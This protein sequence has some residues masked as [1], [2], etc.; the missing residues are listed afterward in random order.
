MK[1]NALI[2]RTAAPRRGDLAVR[3]SFAGGFG[4]AALWSHLAVSMSD[5]RCQETT[6]RGMVYSRPNQIGQPQGFGTL[7]QV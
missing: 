7:V 3:A 5:C 2:S 4:L 1:R 6:E